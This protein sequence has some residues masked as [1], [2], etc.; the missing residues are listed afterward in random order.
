MSGATVVIP[1]YNEAKTIRD[2]VTRTL[3]HAQAVIVVDDGSIDGTAGLIADLPVT[4]LANERN[5]GKAASIWRGAER[6]LADGAAGIYTLDGDGQHDPA[7]LRR[8]VR[9]AAAKPN[10]IIVGARL[11]ARASIPRTR[12]YVNRFANFWVAWAAGVPIEDT[13]SGFRYYPAATFRTLALAHGPAD[14]FVFESEVLIAAAWAGVE[15]VCVPISVRYAN[16]PRA[17]HFRP[18]MDFARVGAMVA[19]RLVGSG[20]NPRGLVRSLRSRGAVVPPAET[21]GLRT[22]CSQPRGRW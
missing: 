22:I 5:L 6:A 18:I 20:F 10:A 1:A 9:G 12:Y 14:S 19:R 13:Q 16:P 11:H 3:P 15:I 17:S 8:M 21:A 7:D 2:V 4:V